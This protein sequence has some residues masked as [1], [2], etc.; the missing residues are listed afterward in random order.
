MLKKVG[1]FIVAVALILSMW[2][3]P[4]NADDNFNKTLFF[5]A[6]Y[7][8]GDP[9]DIVGGAVPIVG[10]DLDTGNGEITYVDSEELGTKV[11][12]FDGVSSYSYEAVDYTKMQANFTME[13]YINVPTAVVQTNSFAFIAGTWYHHN[14]SGFGFVFSEFTADGASIGAGRKISFVQGNGTTETS[15]VGKAYRGGW[16][17]LVYTHD[18]ATES[19]YANGELV[20]S[21]PVTSAAIPTDTSR[22]FRVGG[23]N[24]IG[25]FCM[26]MQCA[27]VRLFAQSA[28]A[29]EVTEL[30]TNRNTPIEL[31]DNATPDPVVTATPAPTDGNDPAQ[32][33]EVPTITSTPQ[34]DWP[35]V[36]SG[37]GYKVVV[38]D[39]PEFKAGDKVDITFKIVDIQD[40]EGLMGVDLDIT[41]D[42][43]ALKPLKD[44]DGRPV[45][46]SSAAEIA[47]KYANAKWTTTARLDDEDTDTPVYVLKMFTDAEGDSVDVN[48]KGDGELWFT[49][50]FEA[51][52]DSSPDKLLAY[53]VAAD[54]TDSQVNSVQGTGAYAFVEGVPEPTEEPS[55]DPSATGTPDSGYSG[56]KGG[57]NTGNTVTFDPGLISLAA[58]ALS[59][60]V[61]VKKKKF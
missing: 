15:M 37:T 43:T 19:Y 23:Y 36:P 47:E 57:S 29:E 21:Q 18:G 60:V 50:S 42:T 16:M 44:G 3:V 40:P 48:I 55:G 22:M 2:T 35:E 46:T 49:V 61:A 56:N 14:K 12:S 26:E 38:D 34:P 13:A 27:Y 7:T 25:Q 6:D 9:T 24:H 52:A 20:L 39:I 54:G 33:T 17:H 28:T 1:A 45:V 53:T 30:Y 8:S 32:P 31:D 10:L 41:Y 51:L 11:A 58:V 59:S 4:V 5:Y